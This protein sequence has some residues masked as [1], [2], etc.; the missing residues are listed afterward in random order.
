M[1]GTLLSRAPGVAEAW[2]AATDSI[3]RR[4]GGGHLTTTILL[5]DE[6]PACLFPAAG[7]YIGQEFKVPTGLPVRK[8]LELEWCAY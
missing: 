7:S 4:E 3:A 6:I 5:E 2:R 8:S 1:L